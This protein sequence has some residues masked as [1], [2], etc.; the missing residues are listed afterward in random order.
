MLQTA[1]AI[2]PDA[3]PGTPG[4]VLFRAT[5]IGV[6]RGGEWLVKGVDLTLNPGEIVTLIGPNGSGK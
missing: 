4:G 1:R 3:A 5:G 2:G 6:R